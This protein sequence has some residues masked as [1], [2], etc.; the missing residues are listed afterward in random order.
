MSKKRGSIQATVSVLL[1]MCAAFMLA[2]FA[3][4][5]SA[6]AAQAQWAL[7]S[8]DK[9]HWF[10]THARFAPDGKKLIVNLCH[11]IK[12]DY[13]KL[14]EYSLEQDQWVVLPLPAG[15]SY[16]WPSY[17]P[18]GKTLVFARAACDGS[19]RC[20]ET[21]SELM[22]YSMDDG[23]IVTYPI[24]GQVR[25]P[26]YSPD[27]KRLAYWRIRGV[28]KLA[29]GRL[30][31]SVAIYEYELATGQETEFHPSV[32]GTKSVT[33]SAGYSGPRYFDEGRQLVYC[34]YVT[35]MSTE[36][37]PGTWETCFTQARPSGDIRLMDRRH[38][39]E[40]HYIEAGRVYFTGTGLVYAWISEQTFLAQG[41]W[42]G[43]IDF[44]NRDL[45]VT[46]HQIINP[47]S[48]VISADLSPDG[49]T[50][51]KVLGG[52][53]RQG[54]F[55]AKSH[56]RQEDSQNFPI[57]SLIDVG[58]GVERILKWPNPEALHYRNELDVPAS[59][60]THSTNTI[61]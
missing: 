50:V 37:Q 2:P 52:W 9:V 14:L 18:D 33:F 19:H 39:S 16:R 34:G 60:D 29:S 26:S 42:L 44:S 4:A 43:F 32:P 15:Y 53:G 61:Q 36:R 48:S 5:T 40:R 6:H 1:T 30:Y 24:A 10:P 12:A 27:G 20:E 35:H 28:G 57:M 31:G 56:Y 11:Y 55:R 46:R 51:S 41:V 22:T 49:K 23:R 7:E 38:N 17:S 45:P 8:G 47:N 25:F 58:N 54:I 13:C 59:S 21:L 3:F